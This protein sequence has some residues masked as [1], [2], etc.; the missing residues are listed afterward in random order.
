MILYNITF[1]IEKGIQE[2][3]IDFLKKDYIPKAIAGGFLQKPRLH[4]IL[5]TEEE[6]G[7]SLAL[8]FQVK[9]IDTLDFWLQNEGKIIHE[10]LTGR[11][12]YQI[13][14]FATLLE[15]IDWER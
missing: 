15:E 5:R 14:G 4:R 8:Q 12:G 7:V 10:Q 3:G 6:E 13:A 9:N 11:F 2:E 1:H